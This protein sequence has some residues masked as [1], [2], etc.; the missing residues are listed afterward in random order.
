MTK[1]VYFM[2]K[3]FFERAGKY[4]KSISI[5]VG[6]YFIPIHVFALQQCFWQNR[7]H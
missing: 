2:N 5:R 4:E 7:K 1:S 3:D 6:N